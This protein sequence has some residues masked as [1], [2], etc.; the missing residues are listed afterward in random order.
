M[1]NGPFLPPAPA[2][3]LLIV[4]GVNKAVKLLRPVL[5]KIL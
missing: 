5:I 3:C 1:E 2:V 4:L